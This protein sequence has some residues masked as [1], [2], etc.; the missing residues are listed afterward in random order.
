M[1]SSIRNGWP[2][3]GYTVLTCK[4]LSFLTLACTATVSSIMD[5]ISGLFRLANRSPLAVRMPID[6]FECPGISI[7]SASNP[8]SE[9]S[10]PSAI[11][12]SGLNLSDLPNRKNNLKIVLI[13]MFRLLQFHNISP[14]STIPESSWCIAICDPNFLRR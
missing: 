5:P 12:K 4:H 11:N 8:H 2:C 9:K 10:Y 3:P 7:A 14:R 13:R 6:P 1:N